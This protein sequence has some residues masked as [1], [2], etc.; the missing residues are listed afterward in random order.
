[1]LE[2]NSKIIQEQFLKLM[3]ISEGILVDYSYENVNGFWTCEVQVRV[4]GRNRRLWSSLGSLS[5]VN[6]VSMSV[7]REEL[8]SDFITADIVCSFVET[9]EVAFQLLPAMLRPELAGSLMLI[10]G[11]TRINN[12]RTHGLVSRLRREIVDRMIQEHL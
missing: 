8:R 10:R 6:N 11:M 4:T 3:W 9:E 7:T 5:A 2:L 12:E 1:M